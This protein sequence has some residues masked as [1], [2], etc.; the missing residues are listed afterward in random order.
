MEMGGLA[1][2]RHSAQNRLRTPSGAPATGPRSKTGADRLRTRGC[3]RPRPRA[4]DLGPPSGHRT[5]LETARTSRSIRWTCTPAKKPYTRKTRQDGVSARDTHARWCSSREQRS[6]MD[7][8]RIFQLPASL[9]GEPVL[10]PRR[11]A[12]RRPSPGVTDPGRWEARW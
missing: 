9:P 12:G 4:L 10:G 6:A 1:T 3:G 2:W 7:P 11:W 5:R 8:H